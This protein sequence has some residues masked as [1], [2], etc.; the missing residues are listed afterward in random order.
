MFV[1]DRV[2]HRYIPT[3]YVCLYVCIYVCYIYIYTYIY[4][5]IYKSY[6]GYTHSQMCCLEAL[7][8]A[9]NISETEKSTEHPGALGREVVLING[10]DGGDG[11]GGAVAVAL[12][13]GGGAPRGGV[14]GGGS[15][16]APAAVV[17]MVN[18]VYTLLAGPNR[19]NAACFLLKGRKYLEHKSL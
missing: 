7:S 11:S 13:M 6:V 16:A 15:G 12:G 10:G 9:C 3:N 5:Y 17:G 4:I 2:I 19:R 8:A 1:T 14:A 18:M